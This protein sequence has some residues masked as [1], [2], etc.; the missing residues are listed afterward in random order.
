MKLG[1][2]LYKS[3]LNRDN[4]QFAKQAGAT[5]LVIQLVDYIKGGKNPNLTD[6]H[7]NGWGM[8]ENQKNPWTYEEL[9]AI[10]REI[11]SEGLIWEAIENIDPSHW[12]DILLDGPQKADQ[13]ENLKNTLQI[14]GQVG[15]RVLGYNFSIPGVWGWTAKHTGRGGAKSITFDQSMIDVDSPVPKGM[16]WNMIYDSNSEEGFIEPM[17]REEL[18]DRLEYFLD[19]M[20]PIAEENNI[21][22]VAHPDDPPLREMRGIPKLLYSQSEYE[23]LLDLNDSPSSGFELCMG[24]VQEMPGSDIYGFLDKY[25]KRN[26]IGYVHCRNVVGKVPNYREAFIDEGDI[27]VIKAMRILKDNN[28]GGVIIPDHTPEMSCDAPWHAGMAYAL[29]Y[30]KAVLQTLERE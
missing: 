11:E 13:I 28:Y 10:K 2:G 3:V 14:M 1:L 25:S 20:I 21:M 12:F 16:L 4:Y 6:D 8:S 26:K 17:S 22:L 27:D 30:L 23:H 19:E 7:F 15:I 9:N 29:G 18:W 24:T 5:H